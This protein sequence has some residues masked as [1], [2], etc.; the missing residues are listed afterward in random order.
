MIGTRWLHNIKKLYFNDY[1]WWAHAWIVLGL[2]L[3]HYVLDLV[4]DSCVGVREVRLSLPLTGVIK[5]R[6]L[7]VHSCM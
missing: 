3:T 1:E 2:F 7:P 5:S 6:L 4:A